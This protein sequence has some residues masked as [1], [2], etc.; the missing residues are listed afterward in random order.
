MAGTDPTNSASVFR[1]ANIAREG[2][3]VRVTWICGGGRTNVLE[4]DLDIGGSY[5]NVSPNI[6]L[7]G[8]G[9]TV[10]NYLDLGAA[11]NAATRFYR[12]RLVP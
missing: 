10:T 8:S 9:D 7:P 5:S 3:D 2:D 4:S 11:T 1:I 12:V 6:I